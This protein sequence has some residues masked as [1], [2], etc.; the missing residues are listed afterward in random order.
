MT[1]PVSWKDVQNSIKKAVAETG[2]VVTGA[3]AWADEPQP[4]AERRL[5]L[6][7]IYADA[8]A[9]RDDF[10]VGDDGITTTWTHSTLYF[11][12]VQVRAESTQAGPGRDALF[13]LEKA[14]TG[15]LKPTLTLDAGVVLQPDYQTYVHHLPYVS[16]GRTVSAW[17]FE[18]NFRA[19][20]DS[21]LSGPGDAEPNMVQV[22][23]QGELE[24]G[25]TDPATVDQTIDR[26]TE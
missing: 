3:T 26:P 1:T 9:E 7:I 13:F 22:V 21:P 8:L 23:A 4:A 17:A 2:A 6:E 15:L 5:I 11:I 25:E 20:I 14:R 10:E 16:G 12:R 18:T 24:V 19:V